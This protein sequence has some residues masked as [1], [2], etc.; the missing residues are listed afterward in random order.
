MGR[1]FP[2]LTLERQAPGRVATGVPRFKSLVWLDPEKSRRKRDS[3]P[4]SSTLEADALTTR[5]MKRCLPHVAPESLCY[6]RCLR[7]GCVSI[8]AACKRAVIAVS[9]QQLPGQIKHWKNK[10][11]DYLNKRI[12]INGLL[13]FSEKWEPSGNLRIAVDIY[14]GFFFLF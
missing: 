13:L 9:S 12:D 14:W 4:V 6:T 11:D 2:A 7:S 1:P 10:F 5:R 8:T 3:N